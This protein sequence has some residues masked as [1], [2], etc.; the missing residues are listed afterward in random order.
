MNFVLCYSYSFLLLI[1]YVR[2]GSTLST[3]P[4][5][6]ETVIPLTAVL[7]S[8]HWMLLNNNGGAELLNPRL[9]LDLPLF[10]AAKYSYNQ[11]KP[12]VNGVQCWVTC[13]TWTVMPFWTVLKRSRAS[14]P[15]CFPHRNVSEFIC[16]DNKCFA[17][18]WESSAQ[19]VLWESWHMWKKIK[20]MFPAPCQ[21]RK[22][23][24]LEMTMKQ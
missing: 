24:P 22:Q 16:A 7:D 21:E 13:G 18:D 14:S 20:P 8:G 19:N 11:E 12:E 15:L 3:I 2:Y 10:Q 23:I 9:S 6:R 5:D 1:Q 17:A 4:W